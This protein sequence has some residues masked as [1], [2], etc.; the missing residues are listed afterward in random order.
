MLVLFS[1]FYASSVSG[2]Y[3]RTCGTYFCILTI[4]YTETSMTMRTYLLLF[5][6]KQWPCVEIVGRAKLALC[7]AGS[8][9][10]CRAWSR[11]RPEG[12]SGFGMS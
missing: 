9:H 2:Q 1:A 7:S 11:D 3:G 4:I 8:L 6:A 5:I 12:F 10:F